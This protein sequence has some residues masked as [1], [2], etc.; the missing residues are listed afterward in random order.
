MSNCC[1]II[2]PPIKGAYKRNLGHCS[3]VSL[4]GNIVG[5]L[6]VVSPRCSN[7]FNFLK[8]SLS[9]YL[10][11]LILL[12]AVSKPVHQR[13][14]IGR[15]KVSLNHTSAACHLR[16]GGIVSFVIVTGGVPPVSVASQ[17]IGVPGWA[18]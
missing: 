7:H 9:Y 6:D 16:G 2:K 14:L 13:Q 11:H 4:S 10:M 12:K 15:R 1:D 18:A 3:M 8:L 5:G 17:I